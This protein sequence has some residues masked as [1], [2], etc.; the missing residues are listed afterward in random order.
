MFEGEEM[1]SLRKAFSTM[2]M[3]LTLLSLLGFSAYVPT[4]NASTRYNVPLTIKDQSGYDLYNYTVKIVL[5]SSNFP[6]WGHVRYEDGSDIYFLD[7]EGNPLYYWIEYFNKTEEKAIIWVKIPKVSA[8]S[9][10]TIYMCYGGTNP[11]TDYNDKSNAFLWYDDFE[12]GVLEA[13]YTNVGCGSVGESNGALYFSDNGDYDSEFVYIN[14]PKALISWSNPQAG[15]WIRIETRMRQGNAS[16]ANDEWGV[17]Y[18]NPSVGYFTYGPED[19]NPGGNFGITHHANLTVSGTDPVTIP[20]PG[21]EWYNITVIDFLNG[22][23]EAYLNGEYEQKHTISGFTEGYLAFAHHWDN[24]YDTFY[25]DYIIVRAYVDPEPLVSVGTEVILK[26]PQDSLL[27]KHKITYAPNSTQF[28]HSFTATNTTTA[29]YE[30]NY[31]SPYGWRVYADPYQSGGTSYENTASLVSEVNITLPYSEVL[32]ENITLLAKTNGTGISRQLWVKVLNSTGD[33]VVELTNATIGTGWTEV[34]LTV[35]AS[36]SNQITIWINATVKSTTTAGEEIAVKDVRVYIEY[37][38]NPQV[39]VPWAPN[40]EFFNCSASHYV[41]LGSSEY[42]NSSTI[43]F[44]LIQYLTYNTTDYPVQPVYIGEETVGSYN[45]SVY[46][47]EPANY[48]QSL[49]VYALLENKLK[50]FRTHAEGF[51]TETI[52]IGEPLTV[53]LPLLGNITIPELN[54]TFINVTSVKIVF[55]AT[56]TFTLEANS[57]LTS[58]WKLGYGMKTITVKYG[59]FKVEP[60]DVDSK[61]IDYEDMVLQLVNKSSGAVVR[62]LTGNRLFSLDNLWA[63]NYTIVIKLKDL[64]VGVRDFELNITTDASVIDM[65]CSMKSL[66]KDY[67]GFSRA[68]VFEHDKQLLKVENLNTKFPYSRI[69]LLLNGTG[70]FKLYINYRGDLPTKV[71]V[72]GNVTNLKYYWDGN[73]LAIKGSLGSTGELTIT[74]LYRLRVELYDRLGNLMPSWIYAY[75][76]ESKYSGAMVEAYLYPEDYEIKLP[77]TINDFKFYTW[78]DG[79]KE[80]TRIVSINNTDVVFKAWYRVSTEVTGLKAVKVSEENDTVTVYV[81]GYLKDY[82]GNGV[83]NRTV[84]V[85]VLNMET[86]YERRFSVVTD[87]SGYFRTPEMDLAKNVTYKVSVSWAGDDIY[88]ETESTA[89]IKPEKVAPAPAPVIPFEI[90][91][92]AAIGVAAAV[93]AIVFL[94]PRIAK[95]TIVEARVRRF[96]FVRREEE[97]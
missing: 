58:L 11:Y 40:V 81:E 57:T 28:I 20:E 97:E 94:A 44:K 80:N 83:A 12:D 48:S 89:E 51:D 62:E 2:L 54:K 5:N 65:L 13:A 43:V 75:I 1:K 18:Y 7:G 93:V 29:N 52:L 92:L 30:T 61:V 73:Y 66:V 42:L 85:R 41:E 47:V 88:V 32:V 24:E 59:A 9:L 33:I 53:E 96:K 27:L 50:T 38:T 74:D 16:D 25:V 68:I 31:T 37:E 49:T 4:V 86:L 67:R 64:T 79:L 17:G 14:S 21:T 15:P 23:V 26:L 82:Y 76:N 70:S 22:T 60:M 87:A 56:G 6:Y 36:L 45:Y 69:R 77:T 71:L 63:E 8:N 46:R 90:A 55:T 95:K 78:F 39:S 35:N 3:L 84:E 10:T 72:E 19:E 91:V 34:S